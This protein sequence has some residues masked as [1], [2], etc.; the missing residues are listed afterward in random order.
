MDSQINTTIDLPT[1]PPTLLCEIQDR[2]RGSLVRPSAPL[3]WSGIITAIMTGG[4]LLI[5]IYAAFADLFEDPTKG[6]DL[7]NEQSIAEL[8]SLMSHAVSSVF[9][10]ITVF[11]LV[12]LPFSYG[13]ALLGLRAIRSEAPQ[14]TDLFAPYIRLWD[15]SIFSIVLI[16]SGF[17]PLLLWIIVASIVSFVVS[18]V[19]ATNGGDPI[20]QIVTILLAV[21][22]VG[23]PFIFLSIYFQFRLVYAGI[24]IID[25]TSGRMGAL[26]AIVKSWRM[27][28]GQNGPLSLVALYAT[29]ALIRGT[30]FGYLIGFFTRGLPEFVALFC[31]SYDV[32][33]DRLSS[34]EQSLHGSQ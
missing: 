18:L 25:P 16:L 33:A 20:G 34:H 17:I 27:T 26:P 6:I 9:I 24:A 14:S 2:I 29:W 4:P 22:I 15:F 21:L 19:V 10:S 12:A 1:H 28:R 8:S 3:I 32:L 5:A 13:A 31:G 30:I 23:I 11:L 7:S